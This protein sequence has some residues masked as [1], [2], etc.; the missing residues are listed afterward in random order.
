MAKKKKVVSRRAPVNAIW[1]AEFFDCRGD[2][3]VATGW[4]MRDD[5]RKIAAAAKAEIEGTLTENDAP[6]EELW[7]DLIRVE[8]DKHLYLAYNVFDFDKNPVRKCAAIL[9]AI[10]GVNGHWGKFCE[11]GSIAIGLSKKMAIAKL[12]KLE[13]SPVDKY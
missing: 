6:P 4:L 13:P 1:Y 9:R 5:L 7:D 3:S 2:Q 12:R 11:E 10:E 8:D